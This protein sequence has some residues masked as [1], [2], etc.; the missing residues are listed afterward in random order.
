MLLL[1]N[2]FME[3]GHTAS[4]LTVVDCFPETAAGQCDAV[5]C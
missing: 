4:H 1:E 5:K 3:L 2:K